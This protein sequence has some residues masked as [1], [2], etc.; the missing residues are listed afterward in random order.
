MTPL[1]Y[2]DLQASVTT[3]RLFWDTLAYRRIPPLY[4]Y[5]RLLFLRLYRIS[6]TLAWDENQGYIHHAPQLR[7]FSLLPLHRPLSNSRLDTTNV[8]NE[9]VKYVIGIQKALSD[10]PKRFAHHVSLSPSNL[11]S[12][13]AGQYLDAPSDTYGWIM[14]RPC[15]RVLSI[16]P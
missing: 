5:L 3:T 13:A 16:S 10:L 7:H 8:L 11:H 9:I 1:A 6:T 12:S 2:Y 15:S 4:Y 14:A